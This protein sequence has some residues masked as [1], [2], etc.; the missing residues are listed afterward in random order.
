MTITIEWWI[1]PTIITVLAG[2]FAFVWP[3]REGGY[4]PSFDGW[5]AAVVALVIS[6]AAWIVAGVLK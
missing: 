5:I 1:L 3:K 6:L 4:L 2:L